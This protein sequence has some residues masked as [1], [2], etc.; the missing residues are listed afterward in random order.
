MGMACGPPHNV[1][2][3]IS[4]GPSAIVREDR[5]LDGLPYVLGPGKSTR[6]ASFYTYVNSS[7]EINPDLPKFANPAYLDTENRNSTFNVNPGFGFLFE[8]KIPFLKLRFYVL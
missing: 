6:P 8:S 7:D 3:T 2:W 4:R 5:D 1:S